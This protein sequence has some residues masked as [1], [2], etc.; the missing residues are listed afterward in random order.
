MDI[1]KITTMEMGTCGCTACQSARRRKIAKVVIE[2][3]KWRYEELSLHKIVKNN[4]NLMGGR[5]YDLKVLF[6]I[7]DMGMEGQWKW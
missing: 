4:I 7:E 6:D 2:H 5:A 3:S 1:L